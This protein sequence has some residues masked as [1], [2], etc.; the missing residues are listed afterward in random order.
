[1]YVY[2]CFLNMHAV[3]YINIQILP[4]KE[5][6]MFSTWYSQFNYRVFPKVQSNQCIPQAI[7]LY[8]TRSKKEV[9]FEYSET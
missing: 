9:I 4:K 5:K 7:V 8:R 1:M 3:L 2:V 6:N